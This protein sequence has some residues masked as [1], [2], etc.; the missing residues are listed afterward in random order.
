MKNKLKIISIILLSIVTVICLG[1]DAWYLYIL[2]N[3]EDKVIS[4]TFVVGE[5]TVSRLDEMTGEETTE[6]K[7]FCEVNIYDDV[8]EVKF[9]NLLDETKKY[10][11]S[12]GIQFI[13]NENEIDFSATY[14]TIV[15]TEKISPTSNFLTSLLVGEKEVISNRLLTNISYNNLTY[16][17]YATDINS[18]SYNSTNPVTDNYF[19]KID[20]NGEIYGMEFNKD[21]SE[22]SQDSN[23]FLGTKSEL[24]FELALFRRGIVNKIYHEFRTPDVFFFAEEIYNAVINSTLKEGSNEKVVYMEFPDIFNYYKFIDGQYVE[25][26]VQTDL[27][28]KI[29]AKI[30]NY[31]G[32]KINYHEGKINNASQSLFGM[33]EGN[34]NYINGDVITSDYHT[35]KTLLKLN[36]NHFEWVATSN[37]G[38]YIFKLSDS[39]KQIYKDYNT[40]DLL[41]YTEFSEDYLNDCNI[42][43]IGLEQASFG[44]F[45]VYKAVLKTT[46]GELTEVAYA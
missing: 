28:S 11:Y 17:T 18:N 8:Y 40:S 41:L 29:T 20:L 21:Y 30:K 45:K 42:T 26:K 25:D 36:E 6:T 38:E 27:A 1:L 2:K 46:A 43:L 13:A 14:G 39:F 31:Y 7:Y 10:F 33:V 22:F 37:S 5:Q 15:K 19:F 32:I 16:K 34:A 4:D 35:G 24:S 3:G 44:D 9:N 12:Q 23:L